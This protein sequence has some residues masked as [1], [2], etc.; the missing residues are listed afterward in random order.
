MDYQTEMKQNVES[1]TNIAMTSMDAQLASKG[2][3][4]MIYHNYIDSSESGY[5]KSKHVFSD[6]SRCDWSPRLALRD[7]S[8]HLKTGIWEETLRDPQGCT[9]VLPIGFV[10]YSDQFLSFWKQLVETERISKVDYI[11]N[12]AYASPEE[13]NAMSDEEKARNSM[14]CVRFQLADSPQS[15]IGMRIR[16]EDDFHPVPY[17][18]VRESY[19]L[20]PD[21][22]PLLEKETEEGRMSLSEHMEIVEYTGNAPDILIMKGDLLL[23]IEELPAVLERKEC[24]KYALKINLAVWLPEYLRIRL[25]AAVDSVIYGTIPGTPGEEQRLRRILALKMTPPPLWKQAE[26]VFLIRNGDALPVAGQETPLQL[27]ENMSASSFMDKTCS[28]GAIT[29][30]AALLLGMGPLAAVGLGLG[31]LGG[32]KI[33][34]ACLEGREERFREKAMIGEEQRDDPEKHRMERIWQDS[35]ELRLRLDSLI[36]TV[37]RNGAAT[38]P[39]DLRELS[40]TIRDIRNDSQGLLKSFRS[41]NADKKIDFSVF[42]RLDADAM[43]E[44]GRMIDVTFKMKDL[45]GKDIFAPLEKACPEC[46][47]F[48]AADEFAAGTGLFPNISNTFL[49][50][51]NSYFHEYTQKEKENARRKAADAL[52]RSRKAEKESEE[53]KKESEEAKIRADERQAVLYEM[54]HHI[55]NLVVSVIDPLENMVGTVPENSKHVLADA[56]NGANMIRQIVFFITNSY[57]ST[58]EDFLY[59]LSNPEDTPQTMESLFESTLRASVAN[60]FDKQTHGKYMREFFPSR[61]IF[62]QA[63]ENW[64]A[65]RDLSGVIRFMNDMMNIRTEIALDPF[66]SIRI[67]DAKGSAT[68]LAILFNELIMNMMKALAFVPEKDRVFHVNLKKD[69]DMI[70][71]QFVNTSRNAGTVSHGYGKTIVTNITKGLGGILSS[72]TDGNQYAVEMK[73]PFFKKL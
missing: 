62:M 52:L 45:L 8:A 63:K 2:V 7:L 71:F 14:D 10:Y 25:F 65:T 1:G 35:T 41:L 30:G 17:A 27:E 3:D 22:Y 51:L 9:I 34:K 20:A 18:D 23:G 58:V 12:V 28:V 11:K 39:D 55:K 66:R 67:G 21:R 5:D 57:R 16:E 44:L 61:E 53:A 73:L 31:V 19:V 59:D 72:R 68:N 60:M 32:A 24:P 48:L 26:K 70:V 42:Y 40:G 54:S 37:M 29:G 64:Y 36:S 47:S 4:S 46:R 38:S 6:C 50:I 15:E 43:D 56:I 33:T 13:F 69:E 49:S